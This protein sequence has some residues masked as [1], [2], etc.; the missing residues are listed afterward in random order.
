[1]WT[2]RCFHNPR[3]VRESNKRDF[4]NPLFGNKQYPR[5]A[6]FFALNHQ[7]S[8]AY[9]DMVKSLVIS[10]RLKA[11]NLAPYFFYVYHGK[12]KHYHR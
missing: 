12:D 2:T 1:M 7:P 3:F 8:A 9:Q 6:W 11:P 5:I 10:A 4:F